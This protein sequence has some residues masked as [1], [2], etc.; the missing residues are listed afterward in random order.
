MPKELLNRC[1]RAPAPQTK[2]V[3]LRPE[4]FGGLGAKQH[5]GTSRQELPHPLPKK[6]LKED[7][8]GQGRGPWGTGW[9]CIQLGPGRRWN[10]PAFL[11]LGCQCPERRWGDS[12][13][14]VST[15]P[16]DLLVQ[17]GRNPK[18]LWLEEEAGLPAGCGGLKGLSVAVSGAV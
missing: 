9:A 13:G 8:E 2:G 5:Q 4:L 17:P 7:P 10:R 18:V 14:K 11:S 1:P 3:E 16:Q 6:S 12:G 15:I